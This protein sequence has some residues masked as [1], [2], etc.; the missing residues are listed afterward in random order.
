[1]PLQ[2]G[3]GPDGRGPGTGRGTGAGRGRG[4]MA[5]D[6]PGSGPA[7][8]C[9]CPN[10]GASARHQRGIPC[11]TRKCPSCGTRMTKA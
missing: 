8:Y 2:D 10:C 4:R 7:G 1:M 9:V 3:T 5:G 11:M 6:K